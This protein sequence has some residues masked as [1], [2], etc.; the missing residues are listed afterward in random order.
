MLVDS[1]TDLVV[2]SEKPLCLRLSL[3]ETKRVDGVFLEKDELHPLKRY[4][5]AISR[6]IHIS[7]GDDFGNNQCIS[8]LVRNFS[9]ER[10]RQRVLV[11][12]WNIGLVLLALNHLPSN[13]PIREDC[14]LCII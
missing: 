4:R 2:V 1:R 7:G 11:P 3:T 5:S 12:Q 8:L 6:T 14:P 10:P 13:T 9:L